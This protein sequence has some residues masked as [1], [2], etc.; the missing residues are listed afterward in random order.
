LDENRAELF[1]C[2]LLAG[3]GILEPPPPG[4]SEI[5]EVVDLPFAPEQIVCSI[6]FEAVSIANHHFVKLTGLELI[7]VEQVSG[8]VYEFVANSVS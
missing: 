2:Q 7:G 4:E 6:T 5:R 3:E 1:A 8:V